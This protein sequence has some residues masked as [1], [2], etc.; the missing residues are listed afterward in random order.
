MLILPTRKIIKPAEGIP[1]RPS[2]RGFLLG[3][4]AALALPSIARGGSLS[5]LGVGKPSSGSPPAGIALVQ[6]NGGS[7]NG[8]VNIATSFGS[9]TTS[10]NTILIFANGAGT[11]TTPSGF[12]S[13][14]PQVNIQGCYLFEKL[15][16][17]GN[18]SDTPTLVMSGAYNATWQIAEYSGITA[19]DTGNGNNAGFSTIT[20]VSTPSITP[21]SGLRQI[22]AFI[23]ASAS[24][25]TGVFDAGQPTSWGN[26]FAGRRSDT[27]TGSAPSGR[28]SMIGGWADIQVTAS[29]ASYSTSAAV[30]SVGGG[31]ANAGTATII[32]AYK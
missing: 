5:L 4:G 3:A 7:I 2:R 15:V 1:Q 22:V 12:T 32:A 16:A 19:L 10:G 17:S 27:Q 13:R 20:S 24:I 18:S 28:D 31:V 11:I 6:Q 21:T 9:A 23:V 14:F 25:Y 30:T 8:N 29:G 26:S